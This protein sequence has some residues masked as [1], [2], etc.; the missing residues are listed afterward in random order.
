[1]S[2][3]ILM[4]VSSDGIVA[5]H[6][7]RTSRPKLV[8]P[9]TGEELNTIEPLLVTVGCALVPDRQFEFESSF[10]KPGAKGSFRRLVRLLKSKPDCPLSIFG[11]ADP[12][13]QDSFNKIL[14]GRRAMAVYAVLVHDTEIWEKQLYKKPH[15]NDDW[16]IRS[17]QII[18]DH[19][20]YSPGEITGRMNRETGDAEDHPAGRGRRD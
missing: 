13:G 15:G 9:A 7:A 14:S 6:P 8:A 17:L 1:M 4:D 11:H 2:D 5:G 12:V 10:I 16:R 3:D 20:G 19:L 18:L